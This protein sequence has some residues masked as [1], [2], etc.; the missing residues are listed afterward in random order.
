MACEEPLM[1]QES[2]V[3][4]ALTAVSGW[5]VD[6]FEMLHLTGGTDLSFVLRKP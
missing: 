5:E 2:A 3:L 4:E 6:D 1:A